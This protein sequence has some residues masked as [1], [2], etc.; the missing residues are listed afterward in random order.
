MSNPDADRLVELLQE[1]DAPQYRFTRLDDYYQGNSPLSYLSAEA[2]AAL[3]KFDRMSS[4]LCRTAV[5][6]LAERLRISGFTGAEVWTDWLRSDLDQLSAKAHRDALLYSWCP[7]IVWT[8]K[9]GR[10]R[11]TI[12]SPKQVAV[13]RDPVDREIVSAV[14]RVRTK[15]TTEAWVYLPDEIQHWRAQTPGAATA[16][17]NLVDTV[18]NPLGVVPVV[19]LG[20][21]DDTSVVADLIP[22]QDAL[23]K[24]LLDAMISSEYAGRP[25]RTATGIE[26]VD[27]PKLDADGSPV[28]D[29]DDQPVMEAV[30]PFPE[31]N[32]M[33]VAAGENAKIGQLPA[34]DLGGFE[35]AVRI[36][37]SQAMMVSGLPAH[38]VG[39]L[40]DSV[41][42]ADAL[43]AAEA[44]LVSRAEAKQQAYGT[45]WESVARLLIAIRDS[46]DAA[47]VTVQIKWA[48]ADTRSTAQEADAVVKL[49]A[50][51]LLPR[52]YALQKLGYSDDEILAIRQA[53]RAEALDGQGVTLG[54]QTRGA[55]TDLSAGVP[56]TNPAPSSGSQ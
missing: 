7:V 41:T 13:L 5:L 34:A 36:I 29:E 50:A 18:P 47:D 21:D 27:R 30:N 25:R 1:L 33:M 20:L 39:L 22:L 51:G 55:A 3:S 42:S 14:K 53:T 54:T 9:T 37:I 4:N 17:F 43:R 48:P 2:K 8:D 49:F 10:A 45:G 44:A 6:S 31:N 40:Q 24:L 26:L 52:A 28:L 12:E 35:A 46:V 32:R 23:N 11:A 19:A 38:Y 15:T 16:G 56:G